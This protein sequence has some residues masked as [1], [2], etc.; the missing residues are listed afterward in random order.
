MKETGQIMRKSID[1][2]TLQ[3]MDSILFITS[4]ITLVAYIMYT[5]A[6]DTTQRYGSEN[7]YLTSI[8]VLLGIMRYLQ[9]T[10]SLKKSG[11]PTEILYKDKMIQFSIIAWLLSFAAIMYF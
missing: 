7:I 10:I 1:G 3:F 2:Y 8:F 4:A 11:S 6:E 5:I 9:I